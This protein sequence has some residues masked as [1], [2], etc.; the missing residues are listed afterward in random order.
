MSNEEQDPHLT[1]PTMVLA[2]L[3]YKNIH[4]FSFHDARV[5]F[6]FL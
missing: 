5:D 4:N 3:L 1:L 6:M 2:N